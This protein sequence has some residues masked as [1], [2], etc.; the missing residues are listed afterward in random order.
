[1]RRVSAGLAR[2]GIIAV[3]KFI[4]HRLQRIVYGVPLGR[5]TYE[6]LRGETDDP[7]YFFDVNSPEKVKEDTAYISRFWAERWLLKR[8]Q[9]SEFLKK[10]TSFRVE[11]FLLSA[12]LSESGPEVQVQQTAMDL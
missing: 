9:R 6:Y 2:I 8:I 3:D 4:R 5:A 11:D 12:E 7:E 10:V 1:L